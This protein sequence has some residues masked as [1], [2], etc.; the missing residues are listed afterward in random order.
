LLEIQKIQRTKNQIDVALACLGP[1]IYL[2]FSWICLF[3]ITICPYF[4]S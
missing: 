2:L 1:H 4:D 3:L